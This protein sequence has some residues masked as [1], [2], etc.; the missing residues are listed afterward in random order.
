MEKNEQKALSFFTNQLIDRIEK[1]AVE[2]YENQLA[3]K[4]MQQHLK[5]QRAANS[6]ITEAANNYRLMVDELES[7]VDIA[8]RRA[9]RL[10]EKNSYLTRENANLR[11]QVAGQRSKVRE[12]K[13]IFDSRNP[14]PVSDKT[15]KE[16]FRE[17]KNMILNVRCQ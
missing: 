2:H 1:N 5:E 14:I 6:E 11:A 15:L 4:E 10:S 17:L 12:M 9:N 8:S 16:P 3:L 13:Q 7:L